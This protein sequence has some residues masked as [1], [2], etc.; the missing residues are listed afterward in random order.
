MSF[1]FMILAAP[2]LAATG[3]YNPQ[4][5]DHHGRCIAEP[6][7]FKALYCPAPASPAA[8]AHKRHR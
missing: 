7:T 5:V 3:I 4:V 6:G 2:W 1:I 8:P